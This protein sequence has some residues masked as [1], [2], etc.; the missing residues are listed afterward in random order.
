VVLKTVGGQGDHVFGQRRPSAGG[1]YTL[2]GKQIRDTHFRELPNPTGNAPYRLD[3]KDVVASEVYQSIVSEKRLTFH[4]NGDI[5]GIGST[6]QQDL[7]ATGMEADLAIGA[8]PAGRP[9]FLYLTGDCVYYNGEVS[10]YYQ[11]FYAPYKFYNVPIFAVPGNH[12]GE[13]IQGDASLNGFMRNFCAPSPVKQPESSDS[14]RT[15]MVQPNVYWTLLTPVVNIVGLYSNVPE[16]GQIKSPQIDWLVEELRDLPADVPLILALH[17]PVYSADDHHSGSTEM[18]TVIEQ[19]AEQAGRHPDM[20]IAGHV[21]DYQRLTKQRS[22]GS[23]VPYLVT[24]AGGYPNLHSIQK[25]NGERMITPVTFEDKGND[26]VTLESYSDDHHGFLRVEV[27]PMQFTGRY[28]EVPR[29]QE[30]YSKGSHLV[31][32]FQYSWTTKKY[33]PNQLTN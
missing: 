26:P 27:T 21:H 3:L 22:D 24:G 12:D 29:P 4:L 20:V 15:A 6:A 11:Q 19:A 14:L 30:P 17:H 2:H 1:D 13:N 18:K 10:Q 33:E 23:Q 28:Y 31:D 7:V 25:V 9:A 32:H 16:G 8:S 5:G